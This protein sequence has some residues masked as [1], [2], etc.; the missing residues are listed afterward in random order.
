VLSKK[1]LGGI[2]IAKE[3]SL[4]HSL[5]VCP[6]TINHW[7]YGEREPR[8]RNL[9]EV[10]PSP[11]LSYIIGA[12]IGDGSNLAKSGCVKL[13]VSDLDFAETFNAKMAALFSR[14]R[15]NKVLKRVFASNRLPLFI[16]KYASNQLAGV[17]GLPLKELLGL[18]F[19]YPGEFLRGLFDA[20]G[21]VDVTAGRDFSLA[22][23]AENSDTYLLRA[24]KRLLR[25]TFGINPRIDRKREAGT[26]KVIRGKSFIMRRTSFSLVI[27]RLG[28]AK[29]FAEHVGFSIRRKDEKLRDALSITTTFPARNRV[30]AWQRLYLKDRGEWVRRNPG[31]PESK[32]I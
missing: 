7:I 5:R 12:N 10:K 15:P 3:L 16:V 4:R 19:A 8:I 22:V 29:R 20:E 31:V 13:E 25:H 23:G 2:R 21:H 1:G 11:E 26:L 28:D 30:V 24:V 18:A 14:K 9:F 6:G 32:D 17:L 27:R